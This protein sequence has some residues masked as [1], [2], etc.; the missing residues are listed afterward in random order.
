MANH[1]ADRG[2]ELPR[3]ALQ[4]ASILDAISPGPAVS[5]AALVRRVRALCCPIVHW[6]W[7][8][9]CAPPYPRRGEIWY[10]CSV[11]ESRETKGEG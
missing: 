7:R 5:R 4:T 3:P 1:N 11:C 6:R 2:E 8:T 9:A 10:R